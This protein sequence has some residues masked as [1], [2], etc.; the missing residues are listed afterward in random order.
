MRN[1]IEK[2][3]DIY[4]NI[5][6][7]LGCEANIISLDGKLDIS[8]EIIEDLDYVMVGLHPMIWPQTFF[9]GYHLLVENI[10]TKIIRNDSLRKKVMRQNTTA[11]IN[12]IKN[13]NIKII[14]HPGLHLPIDTA[15]LAKAAAEN[16]TA[17]E[18]NA[19]H[20]FMTVEY[21]KIARLQ[22]A[23]F[24]IGSDAHHPKDVGRFERALDI[25]QKAGL[26]EED[27]INAGLVK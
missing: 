4:S 1:D 24:A 11:L 15:E 5:K 14:T 10:L 2:I 16:G 8:D 25:V 23:K 22:G 21:V 26:K 27:I 20:G 7:L 17:L 9:D 19:G 6:I 12:A 18:I 13:Y 3:K